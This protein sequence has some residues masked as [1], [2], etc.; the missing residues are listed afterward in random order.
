MVI[1]NFLI[2]IYSAFPLT[3]ATGNRM[4]K[5][6]PPVNPR[7]DENIQTI[8][9]TKLEDFS[10]YRTDYDSLSQTVE[11]VVKNSYL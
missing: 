5:P 2:F 9:G 6:I 4:A 7:S 10:N 11:K 1:Y 3:A 8:P